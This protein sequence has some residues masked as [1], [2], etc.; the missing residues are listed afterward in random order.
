MM[1]G[2]WPPCPSWLL[3]TIYMR[4]GSLLPSYYYT[5]QTCRRWRSLPSDGSPL[6]VCCVFVHAGEEGLTEK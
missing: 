2:V 4:E 5:C 6:R 3:C 1:P